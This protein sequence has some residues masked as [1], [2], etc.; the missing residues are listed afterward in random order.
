VI[1]SFL[2]TADGPCHSAVLIRDGK[3]Q[4]CDLDRG[5]SGECEVLAEGFFIE[6]A[7]Q[8]GMHEN[9]AHHEDLMLSPSRT[10]L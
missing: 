2:E 10:Q 7:A 6:S 3:P 8:H 4:H 5:A 1:I 9:A